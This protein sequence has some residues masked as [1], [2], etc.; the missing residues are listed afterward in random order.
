MKYLKKFEASKPLDLSGPTV[1]DIE[2]LA[3]AGIESY[4]KSI[5][6]EDCKEFAY[7]D[8]IIDHLQIYFQVHFH[9]INKNV[10]DR[11]KELTLFFGVEWYLEHG[12]QRIVQTI[13]VS[14][15]KLKEVFLK[16]FLF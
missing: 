15:S 7:V 13:V 14:K 1:T 3:I 12:P 4:I 2:K 9:S 6:F 16:S 5:Y 11:L 8:H 10:I